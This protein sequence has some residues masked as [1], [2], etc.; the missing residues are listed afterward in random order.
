MCRQDTLGLVSGTDH[1]NTFPNCYAS[2]MKGLGPIPI[3]VVTS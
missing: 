3:I 1:A 2:L